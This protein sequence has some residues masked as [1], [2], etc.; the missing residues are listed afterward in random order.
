MLGLGH[1]FARRRAQ[2][3]VPV[4]GRLVARDG[5]GMGPAPVGPVAVGGGRAGK[6]HGRGRGGG[7]ARGAIADMVT[8]QRMAAAQLRNSGHVHRERVQKLS[9]AASLQIIV[10]TFHGPANQMMQQG[11]SSFTKVLSGNDFFQ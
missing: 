5:D 7:R 8:R 11:R 3:P 10:D 1:L 4:A 9:Q 2:P 6:G